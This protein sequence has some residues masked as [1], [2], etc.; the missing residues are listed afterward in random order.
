MISVE[1]TAADD[2]GFGLQIERRKQPAPRPSNKMKK[3]KQDAAKAA[4][5]VHQV[6]AGQ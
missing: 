1:A 6:S 2:G 5:P 4:P 3:K